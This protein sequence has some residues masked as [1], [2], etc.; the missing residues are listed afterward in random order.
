MSITVKAELDPLFETLGLL[1]FSNHPDW[2]DAL[3]RELDDYG[4]EGN[5][6]YQKHFKTVEKYRKVFENHKVTL[7]QETFLF[8]DSS[9]AVFLLL[10]ILVIEHRSYL[11][12]ASELDDRMLRSFLAY[13]VSDTREADGIPP[14]SQMPQLPDEKSMLEFLDTA[15]IKNEDKWYV[16][17][18]FRRPKFW[19]CQLAE[20]IN[21]NL[22]A[23]EKARDAISKPLEKLIN[24]NSD[25]RDP[26]FQKLTETYSDIATVYPTLVQ[27]LM[28]LILYTHGYQGLL[29]RDL[30]RETASAAASKET[31]IRQLKALSE[32]SKLDILCEL[33]H[34][35]MYNLELS[36]KLNLSPSTM[37]HHMN[38]LLTCEFVT[39]EKQDGKVYYCLDK[40]NMEAFLEQLEKLLL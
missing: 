5:T 18:L 22:P 35:S 25:Y 21:L 38:A 13:A 27:P 31:I 6:F 19:F 34:S 39:V 15:D 4:I 33:K 12:D 9:D 29:N 16:L 40:K 28:Q 10:L 23:F 7:P 37:S 26:L 17:D 3:I 20:I 36:E 14:L 30:N 24:D 8:A 2:K 32:K 1:Y 11:A